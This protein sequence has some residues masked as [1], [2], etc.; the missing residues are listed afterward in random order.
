MQRPSFPH[1]SEE[2]ADYLQHLEGIASGVSRLLQEIA[3]VS[4]GIAE[5]MS[6]IR[7]RKAGPQNEKLRYMGDDDLLKQIMTMVDKAEKFQTVEKLIKP[8]VKKEE[9]PEDRNPFE[10]ATKKFKKNGSV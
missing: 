9:A 4:D 5:D 7:T 6:L 10:D 1:L 8:E 2:Q 3:L